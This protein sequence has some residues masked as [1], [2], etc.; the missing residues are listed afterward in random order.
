M[1]AGQN[2]NMTHLMKIITVSFQLSTNVSTKVCKRLQFILHHMTVDNK[3][4]K[5]SEE[6]KFPC[7]CQAIPFVYLHL[8]LTNP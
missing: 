8:T 2:N 3:G 6:Q 7:N 4:R 5:I 1:K